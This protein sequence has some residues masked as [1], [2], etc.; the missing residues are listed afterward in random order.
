MRPSQALMREILTRRR[1]YGR[2]APDAPP[3]PAAPNPATGSLHNRGALAD[4]RARL[5]AAVRDNPAPSDVPDHPCGTAKE[6][7][8]AGQCDYAAFLPKPALRLTTLL[9]L[10]E[11]L[12]QPDSA[13]IGQ[14]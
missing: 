12:Y 7:G 6:D 5:P 13:L 3:V 11:R 9:Q 8:I 4:E 10:V 14:A 1:L 2:I